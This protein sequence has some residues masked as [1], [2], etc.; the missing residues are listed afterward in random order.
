MQNTPCISERLR[1]MHGVDKINEHV[2]TS[3]FTW[4]E[5]EPHIKYRENLEGHRCYAH[6]HQ[7]QIQG[8]LFPI[9]I[10]PRKWL[11]PPNSAG[12]PPPPFKFLDLP[13]LMIS[14]ALA[15]LLWFLLLSH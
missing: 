14:V 11:D 2:H 4:S 3:L 7:G 1:C 6:S 5:K 15:A 12:Y 13:L 10:A 8:Q 9:Q